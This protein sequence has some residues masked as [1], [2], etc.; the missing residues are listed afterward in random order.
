MG[1]FRCVDL[2]GDDLLELDL[3]TDLLGDDLRE[4]EF[5]GEVPLDKSITG[6]GWVTT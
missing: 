1:E 2:L 5:R 6:A 4:A 3:C